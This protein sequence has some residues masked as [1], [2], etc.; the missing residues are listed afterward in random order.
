MK[1]PCFEN[2]FLFVP[3]Q[4][5][6]NRCATISCYSDTKIAAYSVTDG[7][8]HWSLVSTALH[9]WISYK[10][11]APMNTVNL[12]SCSYYLNPVL[13]SLTAV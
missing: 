2:K 3:E 5:S 1:H 8:S 13:S 6:Y 7:I 4:D 9:R 10:F 11:L 12:I